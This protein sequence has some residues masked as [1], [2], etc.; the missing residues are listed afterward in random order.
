M[1]DPA[2]TGSARRSNVVAIAV[3]AAMAICCL[4]APALVAAAGGLALGT[5]LAPVG[6]ALL[7]I[8]CVAAGARLLTRRGRPR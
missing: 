7:A 4:A 8:V 6:A 5:P 1:S 3:G 2:P